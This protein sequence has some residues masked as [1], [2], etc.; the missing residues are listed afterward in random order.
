MRRSA[1][2]KRNGWCLDIVLRG[3]PSARDETSAQQFSVILTS[4]ISAASLSLRTRSAFDNVEG[5]PWSGSANV[6]RNDPVMI[7]VLQF[8]IFFMIYDPIILINP[9]TINVLFP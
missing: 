2:D 3:V 9:I 4:V 5:A 7:M 1:E 8:L 6:F